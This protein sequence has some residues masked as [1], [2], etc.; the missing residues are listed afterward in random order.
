MT[1]IEMS[2]DG[3]SDED[4]LGYF[5]LHCRTERALFTRE[6]F[7]RLCK[8]A[9]VKPPQL[10]GQWYSI[11]ADVAEPLLKKARGF[12]RLKLVP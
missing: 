2:E 10:S 6:Q 4:F 5:D 9:R 11:Y 3:M 1:G 12:Q 7:Y 8:L